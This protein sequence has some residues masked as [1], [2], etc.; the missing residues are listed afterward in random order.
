MV[1]DAHIH[2]VKNPNTVTH[3]PNACDD[4]AMDDESDDDTRPPTG[5]QMEDSHSRIQFAFNNSASRAGLGFNRTPLPL[6]E[7]R[8]TPVLRCKVFPLLSRS[9]LRGVAE[10]TVGQQQGGSSS[11]SSVD[12]SDFERW[13]PSWQGEIDV[14]TP[15]G[16]ERSVGVSR[17]DRQLP[18]SRRR[19]EEDPT[20]PHSSRRRNEQE[21][22][23]SIRHVR[24][25][26]TDGA[27]APPT[28]QHRQLL[29]DIL[30]F[31]EQGGGFHNQDESES[32][33]DADKEE[34]A[35]QDEASWD[36]PAQKH[37]D[38]NDGE[39]ASVQGDQMRSTR[40]PSSSLGMAW[41]ETNET[42]I[43]N[44]GADAIKSQDMETDDSDVEDNGLSSGSQARRPTQD[45]NSSGSRRNASIDS[46][47]PGDVGGDD[48]SFSSRV[49]SN[50]ASN[51][52]SSSSRS[53]ETPSIGLASS[54]SS[55][56]SASQK[57]KMR[58]RNKQKG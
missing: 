20:D 24:E 27:D 55:N 46:S 54:S 17:E 25:E 31:I 28:K 26:E 7:A 3:P 12:R 37:D 21:L 6:C 36:T 22:R 41:R 11:A 58:K 4:G 51:H 29:V 14:F 44:E 52:S 30:A 53:I 38:D 50:L 39:L 15:D 23:G 5:R 33:M 49:P 34:G 48:H 16:Y 43:Y 35:E 40:T 13:A 10:V 8:P 2:W 45:S 56:L 47:K 19:G 18:P 1:Q 32:L 42:K 9:S 57:I